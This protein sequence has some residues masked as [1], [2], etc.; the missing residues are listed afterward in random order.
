MTLLCR[1]ISQRNTSN[2][3]NSKEKHVVP[4]FF[5]ED[6]LLSSNHEAIIVNENVGNTNVS[7]DGRIRKVGGWEI[8]EY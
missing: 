7:R 2:V 3:E 6:P 4:I 8:D 5:E 1:K